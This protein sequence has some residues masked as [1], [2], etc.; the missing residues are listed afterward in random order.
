MT[1]PTP[2]F[3]GPQFQE[4]QPSG[5]FGPDHTVKVDTADPVADA[6]KNRVP[7][8][9][10]ANPPRSTKSVFSSL[11][12]NKKPRSGVRALTEK[13]K[14][15]IASL[16]TFGAMGLMPFRPKAAQAMAQ[17]AEKCADAWY[18]LAKENDGVRRALLWLMEGGAW[19]GVVF[20][21]TP[22]LLALLP[23]GMMPPMFQSL[24]FSQ[25]ETEESDD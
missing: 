2:V 16:Y 1:D 20:A 14:D 24:D 22:I 11:G 23:E 3:S 18:E 6:I 7:K 12:Q 15:K 17:C 8:I 10:Q 4:P 5:A 19:G 21:H 9:N 13:D 25:F